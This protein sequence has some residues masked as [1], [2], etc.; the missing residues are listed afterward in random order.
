MSGFLA[1]L[2]ARA[3]GEAQAIR[4]RLPARFET[5]LDDTQTAN[6]FRETIE[7]L[8]SETPP[9]VRPARGTPVTQSE[10]PSQS[11]A[12]TP[13]VRQPAT[14]VTAVANVPTAAAP[15]LRAN[16]LAPPAMAVRKPTADAPSPTEEL[17]AAPIPMAP[18]T[19]IRESI[20]TQIVPQPVVPA[21]VSVAPTPPARLGQNVPPFAAQPQPQRPALQPTI[22]VTIG[23]I[24]VRATQPA[25]A[26][27]RAA[28][29]SPVMSLDDYLRARAR[30]GR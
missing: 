16:D 21:R 24:E 14:P 30:G 1:S 2:V 6:P 4:P 20:E 8:P 11:T 22:K 12:D 5:P 23:R 7:E 9:S 19:I 26:P 15:E 17:S 3:R 28:A 27:S 10:I 25:S 29:P 13:G 18:T